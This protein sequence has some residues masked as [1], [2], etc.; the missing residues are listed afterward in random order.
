MLKT[1]TEEKRDRE[2]CITPNRHKKMKKKEN[3]TKI[4]ETEDILLLINS[5]TELST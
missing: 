5:S 4:T 2:I 1:L 3:K